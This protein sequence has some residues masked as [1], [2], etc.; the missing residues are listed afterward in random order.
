MEGWGKMA[1]ITYSTGP[2]DNSAD[3]PYPEPV[4]ATV[5]INILNNSKFRNAKIKIKLFALNGEKT[6]VETLEF[7]VKPEENKERTLNVSTLESFEIQVIV[8][9][10]GSFKQVKRTVLRTAT[11]RDE[12]GQFVSRLPLKVVAD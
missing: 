2:I 5:D 8:R 11:G 12:L 10:K 1:K 9:Q 7:R 6:L 4:Y 3:A